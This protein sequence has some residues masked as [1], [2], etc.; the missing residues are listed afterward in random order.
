MARRQSF[1][2]EQIMTSLWKVEIYLDQ[3][4]IVKRGIKGAPGVTRTVFEFNSAEFNRLWSEWTD[5][6]PD[7]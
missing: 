6:K 4:K 7:T 1:K 5:R 3:G 2:P